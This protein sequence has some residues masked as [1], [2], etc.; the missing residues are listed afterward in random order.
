VKKL[1]SLRGKFVKTVLLVAGFI[2]IATLGIVVF[3]SAQASSEHLA[4]VQKYISEGITS[5]GRVLTENHARAL[6]GL[7]LDNAFLDMQRLV[8]RAVH[9]DTDLVYGLYVN[10]DKETLALSRRGDAVGGDKTPEK[11]SWRALQL[12]DAELLVKAPSV[13]QVTR[14][15]QELVEVAVPVFGEDNELV[16]TIRYGLSTRRMQDAMS[17]AKVEAKARLVRSVSLVASLITV[18]SVLGL[19][20]SR[21]QAVRITRPVA[22]LTHAAQDLASGNRAVRVDVDSGDE[23]E[24]LGASF[25]RMVEELDSSYRELEKMNRTLEHKVE[26]R[27]VELANKNRDMRLVLDNVDQGFITLSVDGFMAQERSRVVDLWFG[28]C[29]QRMRFADYLSQVSRGFAL[30]FELGWD[31]VIEDVLPLEMALYQLPQQL[32]NAGRTW[33]FR[34][35]PFSRAGK[36]DGVLVVIAEIT[37]RLAKE[38][39]EAEQGELMQGFKRLMLDRSGFNSFLRDANQM[40]DAICTRRLESDSIVH[41]RT[42]HTLKGNAA[43]MGLTVVARICHGLEDELGEEGAISEATLAELSTRWQAISEHIASFTGNSSQRVIEIPEAEY[44]ALVSR[45]SKETAQTD[46]LHQ[47]LSWQLEPVSKPLRRLADQAQALARRLDK[48]EVRV[49]IQGNGVRLDPEAY[50]SFFSEL[51]HVVRNAVDHG[52][53]SPDEREARSKPRCGTLVLKAQV[54]GNALTFEIGDDGRGIDWDAVA[55]KAGDL[56]LPNKT[57]QDLLQALCRDGVSTR[58]SVSETSGRGVGMAAF[59]HQVELLGGRLEVRSSR[60]VGTSW[61]IRL[62]WTQPG[63]PKPRRNGRGDSLAPSSTS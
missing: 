51:V 15:G 25:N 4:R 9:E 43:S 58:E 45:L 18:A 32:E 38:R 29:D 37:E 62:P 44:T 22:N 61:I 19:L 28:G 50:G 31:Q 17:Q 36:L 23:I 8:E 11:E 55:R 48:G 10:S 26:E 47:V 3:T 56:G 16:G 53:E 60:G 5:K 57:P 54:S 12:A 30:S 42:L 20:L 59:K 13:R 24:L 34:Y 2:G 46:V 27:T 7:T 41:K 35:L 33:S 39:E 21:M 49:E 14:L 63:A 1:Q 52:L 6:R 40:V